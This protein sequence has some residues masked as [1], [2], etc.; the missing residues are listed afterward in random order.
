MLVTATG[1]VDNVHQVDPLYV[2][3]ELYMLLR[4]DTDVRTAFIDKFGTCYVERLGFSRGNKFYILCEEAKIKN[5][6]VTTERRYVP[7]E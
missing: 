7:Y 6:L 2:T 5:F 3:D 4:N 1:C